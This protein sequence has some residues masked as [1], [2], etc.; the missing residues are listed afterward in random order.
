[1][2]PQSIIMFERLLFAAMALSVINFFVGYDA[3]IEQLEREPAMQQVGL[4][5]GFM[6]VSMVVGVAIYLLLWFFIARKASTVAKWIL[7][8]LTG[9]GVLSFFGTLATGQVPFDLNLLLGILYYVLNVAAMVYLF[10][11]D[12]V[13]WFK[14]EATADPATFD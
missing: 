7:V 1:M 3:M 9:L 2:R 13:R 4:G 8:V 5:G 6:T 12:A 11:E 10:R 14:G